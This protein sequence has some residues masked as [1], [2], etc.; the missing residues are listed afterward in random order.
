MLRADFAMATVTH[1]AGPPA[2]SQSRITAIS[3]SGTQ[4]VGIFDSMPYKRT[5]GT[6]TGVVAPGENVHGLAALPHDASGNYQYTA[7][8]ELIAQEKAG[9]NSTVVIEAENRGSPVL[10]GALHGIAAQQVRLRRWHIHRVWAADFSSTMGLLTRG[11]SGST[12]S[13]RASRRMRRAWAK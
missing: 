11:C 4:P 3:V 5:W 13:R 2:R 7:E 9:T 1:A 8:F 12:E 6:V 10:I